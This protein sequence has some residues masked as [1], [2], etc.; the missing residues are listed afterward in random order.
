MR[1]HEGGYYIRLSVYDRTARL[2]PSHSAWPRK[3][4]RSAHRAAAPRERSAW[5]APVAAEKGEPQASV[6]MV[7]RE[8]TEAPRGKAL[9]VIER[10]GHVDA[11]PQMIRIEKL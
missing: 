6:V 5:L 1:T 7:I 10:D 4:F 9:A 3:G 8:T 2:P 11:K